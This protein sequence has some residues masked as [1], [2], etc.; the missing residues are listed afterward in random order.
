MKCKTCN[1]DFT[2]RDKHEKQCL[3]E[4]L[5]SKRHTS[6]IEKQTQQ[7]QTITTRL[8]NAERSRK[9]NEFNTEIAAASVAAGIPL[10][11]LTHPAFKA[12]IE[13]H[14]QKQLHSRQALETDYLLATY[15]RAVQETREYVGDNDVFFILDETPDRSG[16]SVVNG[17]VGRL[18]GHHT[19]IF[20]LK[21]DF[22]ETAINSSIM[23]RIFMD[24]CQKLW[25]TGVQYDR[26]RL[27]VT[28]A[29]PYMKSCFSAQKILFPSMFH[30]TCLAHAQETI[31]IG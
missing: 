11:T 25:P 8:S 3:K 2:V 24:V 23:G 21:T 1:K 7:Q 22:Y 6:S 16:R 20:L 30:I 19:E 31:L 5:S 13:K 9:Y 15:E 28:D 14:T 10:T 17:L 29:A 12:V 4:H 18:D 27:V 26:V